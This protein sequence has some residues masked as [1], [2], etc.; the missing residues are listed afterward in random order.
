MLDHSLS[1]RLYALPQV[2]S[3]LEVSIPTL[4]RA[5]ALGNLRTVRIGSRRLVSAEELER[6]TREGLDLHK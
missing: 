4:R 5:I 1:K 3:Q 2:A 6:I